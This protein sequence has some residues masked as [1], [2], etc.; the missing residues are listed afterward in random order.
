VRA[1][2][3]KR[4]AARYPL[5]L[6]GMKKLYD[7]VDVIGVSGEHRCATTMVAWR[8]SKERTAAASCLKARC[9]SRVA[10]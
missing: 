3:R 2:H 9:C 1:P 7:E 6:A 8:L 5:D 10:H 4:Q